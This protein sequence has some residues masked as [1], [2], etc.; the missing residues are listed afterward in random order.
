MFRFD[1]DKMF[2]GWKEMEVPDGNGGKQKIRVPEV[3]E[4]WIE[5]FAKNQEKWAKEFE[6]RMERDFGKDGKNFRFLKEGKTIAPNSMIRIQ[7]GDPAKL[8]KSLTESQRKTLKERGYLKVDELT[9]EQRG[10]VGLGEVS[11]D[12][13]VSI[14]INLEGEK[15]EIRSK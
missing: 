4:K 7:T 6:L 9:K 10:M 3:D 2:K 11:K 13:N 8:A 14:I 1:S 12:A 5:E 15:I